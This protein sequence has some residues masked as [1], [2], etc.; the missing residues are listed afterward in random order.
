M[1]RFPQLE[2]ALELHSR[3]LSAVHDRRQQAP[4]SDSSGARAMSIWSGGPQAMELQQ[5]PL[6]PQA[7]HQVLRARLLLLLPLP[8]GTQLRRSGR[9]SVVQEP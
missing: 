7:M 3:S 6:A 9:Q 4:C 5:F 8:T 1:R 2:V